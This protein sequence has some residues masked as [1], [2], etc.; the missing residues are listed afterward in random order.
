MFPVWVFSGVVDHAGQRRSNKSFVAVGQG[1]PVAPGHAGQ[2]LCQHLAVF[3]GQ[4]GCVG[5]LGDIPHRALNDKI[6][7]EPCD[8]SDQG[9]RGG[10]R[11]GPLKDP[12]LGHLPRP[13]Q[14][15][16]PEIQGRHG[17]CGR[18]P[19]GRCRQQ[20]EWDEVGLEKITVG[21]PGD[22]AFQQSCPDDGGGPFTLLSFGAGR[23]P[24]ATTQALAGRSGYDQGFLGV[25]VPL[26]ILA[27]LR[28]NHR[29]REPWLS[30]DPKMHRQT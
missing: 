9:C 1:L 10:L 7:A 19:V 22:V 29:K 5:W 20:P 6:G 17:A 3:P 24:T 30:D 8:V 26:P 15:D 27:A 14:S 11:G 21:P 16:G 25:Q 18:A 23:D 28:G 2:G 4:F 13:I 12:Q